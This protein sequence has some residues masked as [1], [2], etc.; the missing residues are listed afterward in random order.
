[1]SDQNFFVVLMVVAILLPIIPSFIFFKYLPSDANMQ[2]P[3]KGMKTKLG[4][5]FAGYFVIFIVMVG[6]INNNKK[7]YSSYAPYEVWHITGQAVL[8]NGEP[9]LQTDITINPPNISVSKGGT[10][11]LDIPIVKK[12]GNVLNFPTLSVGH[13][14]FNS[15]DIPLGDNTITPLGRLPIQVEKDLASKSLKIHQFSLNLT[16]SYN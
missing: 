11:Y 7:Q 8:Q 1:M 5:A 6:L 9:L 16:S 14:G 3:F 13:H 4:G 15:V 2:G 12:E 10:F